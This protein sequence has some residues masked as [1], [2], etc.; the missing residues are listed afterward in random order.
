V[1]EELVMAADCP[2]RSVP[3]ESFF[4]LPCIDPTRENELKSGEIVTALTLRAPS[5]AA[6]SAHLKVARRQA[7]D[8]PMV[9][10]AECRTTLPRGVGRA[11]HRR[12]SAAPCA[13]R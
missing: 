2:A 9:D 6:R 7:F 1:A 3:L 11:R 12:A 13:R 4:V 10:V 5:A 8:W